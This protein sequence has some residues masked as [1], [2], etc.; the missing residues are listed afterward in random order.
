[1][2]PDDHATASIEGVVTNANDARK[3]GIEWKLP[4][5]SVYESNN[6]QRILLGVDQAAPPILGGVGP[7]HANVGGVLRGTEAEICPNAGDR[8]VDPH[9]EDLEEEMAVPPELSPQD[10][11][12]SAPEGNDPLNPHGQLWREV[13]GAVAIDKRTEDRWWPKLLWPG[14]SRRLGGHSRLDTFLLMCPQV[15]EVAVNTFNTTKSIHI[16]VL[17]VGELLKFLGLCFALG[18]INLRLR[19]DFWADPRN[20][21]SWR[22]FHL[23]ISASGG[24]GFVA[25]R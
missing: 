5:D 15:L 21:E 25:S 9:S 11:P 14:D 8:L 22:I 1:M 18:L 2:F 16:A 23:L 3:L 17:T 24:W 12:S 19:R 4:N 20:Q 6:A 7:P 13:E 10:D